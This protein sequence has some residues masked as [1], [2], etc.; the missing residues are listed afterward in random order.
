[1]N[2]KLIK[3]STGYKDVFKNLMQFYYYDF[4]EYLKFDLEADGLFPPYP[5]L[6]DY[7]KNENDKFPYIIRS[8]Q[9]I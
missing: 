7:F 1:M 5:N 9:T 4:S 2:W 8:K 3:A 6:E